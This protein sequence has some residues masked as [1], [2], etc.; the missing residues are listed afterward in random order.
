MGQQ[1]QD[2]VLLHRNDYCM[3]WFF[4]ALSIVRWRSDRV[5][6]GRDGVTACLTTSNERA[7]D[8][9]ANTCLYYLI[10]CIAQRSAA[11][12]MVAFPRSRRTV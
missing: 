3:A 9:V 2:G 6:P 10:S 11:L 4:K 7:E 1:E 8:G 5:W 12:A